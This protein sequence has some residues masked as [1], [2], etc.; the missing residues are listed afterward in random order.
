MET[1]I[2]A[3]ELA[4]SFW[5]VLSSVVSNEERFVVK[6]NGALIELRRLRHRWEIYSEE[7]SQRLVW[8]L[9]ALY[10]GSPY[11]GFDGWKPTKARKNHE[12]AFGDEIQEG[13]MYFKRQYYQAWDSVLKLSRRSMDKL[14]FAVYG[15][16]TDLEKFCEKLHE[17]KSKN[18]SLLQEWIHEDP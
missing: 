1:Q 11:F 4:K 16:N 17:T 18:W 6:H 12:D 7:E 10:F 14:L 2:S 5:D 13:E 3:E 8:M 15:G 9:N